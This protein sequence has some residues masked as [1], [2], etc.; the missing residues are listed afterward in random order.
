M[1]IYE[2][3]CRKCGQPF[4]LL[5]RSQESQPACPE[6]GSQNVERQFSVPAAPVSAGRTLPVTE[7]RGG[8][9]GLPQC[10]M[11]KCRFE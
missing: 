7:P 1:P 10:G 6:C 5:V 3:Q 2:F 9:C 8:G 11:G 4:E